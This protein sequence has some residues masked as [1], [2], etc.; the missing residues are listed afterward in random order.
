M[1]VHSSNLGIHETCGISFMRYLLYPALL[2]F[3]VSLDG[4]K[5]KDLLKFIHKYLEF[6]ENRKYS[7]DYQDNYQM[8]YWLYKQDASI[9]VSRH[10]K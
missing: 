4:I 10:K 1:S 5:Y 6:L 3:R 8:P 9:L 7:M 2:L